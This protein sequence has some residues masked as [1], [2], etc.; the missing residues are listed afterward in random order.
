MKKLILII[1]FTNLRAAYCQINTEDSIRIAFSQDY[2][3]K[4][5]SFYSIN[6][7]SCLH[8]TKKANNEF[9]FLK[10][11]DKSVIC[12]NS[13]A[14]Q[15]FQNEKYEESFYYQD[16]A[17][18]LANK[19]LKPYDKSFLNLYSNLGVLERF[20][21]NYKRSINFLHKGIKLV[22]SLKLGNN[23][24]YLNLLSLTYNLMGDYSKAEKF[25]VISLKNQFNLIV[26][27][28][29]TIGES[30]EVLGYAQLKQNKNE[31]AAK[32]LKMAISYFKKDHSKNNKYI[33]RK[34]IK[35]Q[36][37]LLDIEILKK[38]IKNVEKKISL[39]ENTKILTDSKNIIKGNYFIRKVKYQLLINNYSNALIDVDKASKYINKSFSNNY[40]LINSQIEDYKSHI[41]FKL[42]KLEES[43]EV[44]E[45]ALKNIIT[46]SNFNKT[47]YIKLLYSKTKILNALKPQK[48]LNIFSQLKT[49]V[50]SLRQQNSTA[51]HKDFWANENL[52][53]YQD[54]IGTFIHQD[55]I[56]TAFTFAEENKSNLLI[57]SLNDIE[58]KTYAGIPEELLD[59]ER[60]FRAKLQFYQKKKFELENSDDI[61]S[62]KLLS[63]AE[64]IT[65]TDFAIEAI[66]DTLENQYPEYYEIKYNEKDLKVEDIQ[67]L[68]DDETAFIEY[69]IG[70]DSSYV[71]TITKN[72][73]L[74]SPLENI[75]EKSNILLNYYNNLNNP[76]TSLDSLNYYSSEAYNLILKNAV[77]ELTPNITNLVIVPD[78]ILN[79]L[80]F[81]MMKNISD[82]TYIGYRYNIQYQYSGRLWRL[83][84]NRKS[85]DK[86]YD[87]LGYA[88]NT[89]NLN[90]LA[91]RAC[92]TM[93]VGNLLCSEKEIKS[94]AD[95]LSEKEL[96][97]N[98][99]NKEDILNIASGAKI[100]HLATHS[101]LDSENSDYSRIFFDDGYITNIDL[102]LQEINA[103][104]AVLSACESGYGELV[105]GEGAMSISKG[106]FHAGCKSTLVSLWPVDDCSTSEFMKHFYTYLQ[107]GDKKDIALK[108][109]K[110]TYLETAHPS[111]TH[112]YYWA[113]FILIGDNAE[114]WSNTSSWNYWIGGLL[115]LIVV[116]GFLY[117]RV[118]AE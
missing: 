32:N 16:S 30:H 101:C 31:A 6:S 28:D 36:L 41:L 88:Y 105:K 65:K 22:D 48:T 103:D 108:K 13:I 44:N 53:I 83:L 12:L 50:K 74:V 27:N 76:S 111:R 112:P 85:E 37:Y 24:N 98:V 77:K 20:K 109:A 84:K 33:K 116:G 117:K 40:S 46:Q 5:D 80:P 68:L 23:S 45:C 3:V 114:V 61:D 104:L 87:F 14:T 81:G 78:D 17:Y 39:F 54:A 4:A 56:N 29:F 75:N 72:E 86:K 93:E 7:D 102:Q 42:G 52:E 70:K 73:V 97:L 26:I 49:E 66:V 1:L 79:N 71:F 100:I 92:T 106:F 69:F 60:E 2:W 38:S 25:A 59:E 91:D 47:I 89:E 63:Y 107:E 11:W 10:K 58:A 21:G 94:I 110:Q 113:G 67:S 115:A 8:Y 19:K 51:S 82:D 34:I 43:L 95:I 15:L 55:D 90:F 9:N 62:S 18:S 57:Q 118:S 35:L 99:N 96:N 64:V